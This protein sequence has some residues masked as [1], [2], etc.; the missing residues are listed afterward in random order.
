VL[1]AQLNINQPSKKVNRIS[2][3]FKSAWVC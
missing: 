3:S 1:K 2:Q